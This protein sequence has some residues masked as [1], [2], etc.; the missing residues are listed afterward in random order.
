M[1]IAILL[2]LVA[3]AHIGEPPAP[4]PPSP[5]GHDA[6]RLALHALLESPFPEAEQ[7]TR[8]LRLV[9]VPPFPSRRIV[10]VRLTADP[11][12]V[13]IVTKSLSNWFPKPGTP[14]IH[15]TRSLPS[16][17]WTEL[18]T[19]LE[20][21][22]WRFHPAPFPNPNMADGSAWFLEAAGPRGYRSIIQHSPEQNAFRELCQALL[23]ASSLD[24]SL[25][26]YSLWFG[27]T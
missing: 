22:F 25:E 12:A 13:E 8:S 19:L 14:S 9:I 20:A 5:W 23:R 26:E 3:G 27:S 17:F 16:T 10:V 24:F 7:P 2:L 15:P 21:G 1:T 11:T 6:V 18:S 4:P